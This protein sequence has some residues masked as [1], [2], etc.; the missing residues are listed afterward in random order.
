M[1]SNAKSVSATGVGTSSRPAA[2]RRLNRKLRSRLSGWVPIQTREDLRR[3]IG[4]PYSEAERRCQAVFVH[5][6]KTAGN[7]ISAAL[8]GSEELG[9]TP[10]ARYQ[11]CDPKRFDDSFKF[12]FVRNPWDR[13]VS[14]FEYLKRGGKRKIDREFARVHLAAFD[15]V[16]ELVTA[17]RDARLRR[18][19]MRWTHF[20]PQ[21][22]W[23]VNREGEIE[24]DFIGRFE[25]LRDDVV[26]LSERDEFER[27]RLRVVNASDRGDY[28]SYYNDRTAEW[29]ADWY[30]DDVRSFGY[31]F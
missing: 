28:R 4:D 26:K 11:R 16:D 15:S 10:L 5:I 31:E 2:L 18:T 3:R 22:R 13:F 23:V 19:F 20:Q 24:L 21:S 1:S 6:P 29:L 30:A 12:A 8:M 9:H 27:G 7:A 17:M 14:A 25:H